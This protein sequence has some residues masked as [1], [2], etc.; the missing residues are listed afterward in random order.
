MLT[1]AGKKRMME[2]ISDACDDV[3]E[4]TLFL[5]VW[6]SLSTAKTKFPKNETNNEFVNKNK[7]NKINN[8]NEN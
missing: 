5:S 7:N 3:T 6:F 1:F 4:S 8:E 2:M